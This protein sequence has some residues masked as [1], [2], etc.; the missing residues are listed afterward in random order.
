MQKMNKIC[1]SSIASAHTITLFVSGKASL[2]SHI[3]ISDSSITMQ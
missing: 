2:C 3:C 1:P